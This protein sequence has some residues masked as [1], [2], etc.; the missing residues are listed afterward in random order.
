MLVSRI[1]RMLP[2]QD[3]AW[4]WAA[5]KIPMVTSGSFVANQRGRALLP[6]DVLKL[7]R[8]TIISKRSQPDFP[9]WDRNVHI[10]QWR[11]GVSLVR[12]QTQ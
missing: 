10:S 11:V 6:K 9:H 5:L 2:T 8:G 12:P 1:V 3:F 4:S 7:P